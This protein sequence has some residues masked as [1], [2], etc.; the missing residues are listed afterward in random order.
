LRRHRLP[1]LAALAAAWLVASP[2]RAQDAPPAAGKVPRVALVVSLRVNVEVEEADLL[3]DRLGDALQE[4]LLV[5]VLGGGE[6]TRRLSDMN[7]AED[8]VGNKAC[9]QKVAERLNADELVFLVVVR[10]G[11]AIQIDP[12]WTDGKGDKLA[13]REAIVLEETDKLPE[14]V[15][16]AAAGRI[17]PHIAERKPPSPQI[18]VQPGQP[19]AP[20]KPARHMT[21]GTWIAGGIAAGALVGGVVFAGIAYGK[22]GDL[23]DQGCEQMPCDASDIDS[24][25]TSMII[26]DS[27]F[28]GALVAGGVAGYLYYR[29]DEVAAEP[30][31]RVSATPTRGGFFVQASGHF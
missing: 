23:E 2:V 24:L 9:V 29:S 28:V 17:L 11:G 12:T 7:V 26:A 14:R 3:A 25:E 1:A 18:V 8:C 15:F 4:K 6:V 21:R 5:D 16:R 31:T 13:A 10:V 20:E 19:V 22:D 27:L 30:S